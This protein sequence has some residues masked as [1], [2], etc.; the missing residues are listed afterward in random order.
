MYV[1]YS[2]KKNEYKNFDSLEDLYNYCSEQKDRENILVK[3]F[4]N[5]IVNYLGKKIEH[6]LLYIYP[7]VK[8][9]QYLFILILILIL[10][11]LIKYIQTILMIFYPFFLEHIK[12]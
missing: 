11:I 9:F 2:E 4:N 6:P 1:I 12:K 8:L 7:I 10:I 3:I 5:D